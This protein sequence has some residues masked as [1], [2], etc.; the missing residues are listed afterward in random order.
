MD[1]SAIPSTKVADITKAF[2]NYQR[3]RE[4]QHAPM[5]A[6]DLAF[7]KL[8]E[9][10]PAIEQTLVPEIKGA[11]VVDLHAARVVPARSSSEKRQR[12]ASV[13][14][15]EAAPKKGKPGRD[16]YDRSPPAQSTKSSKADPSSKS[17]STKSRSRSRSK[18]RT[19][20]RGGSS[21]RGGSQKGKGSG[22][23]GGER[24]RRP[25]RSRVGQG[26]FYKGW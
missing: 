13:G 2:K 17:Q 22:S 12:E 7:A 20:Q 10:V 16:G 24:G 3:G 23:S 6:L 1:V 11:L 26:R 25:P 9:T 18:G 4:P 5:H 14:S 19:S 8:R 15:S 21:N